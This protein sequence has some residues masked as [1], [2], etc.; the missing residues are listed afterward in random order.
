MSAASTVGI[1]AS[2]V[3]SDA[4]V[5]AALGL[6]PH[7]APQAGEPTFT[8]VHTD[9]RSLQPGDLFVALVGE[10]FDAHG[11]VAEA[12][13]AGAGAAVVSRDVAG[14][15][16]DR[17]YRVP[18]TLVA[19][20]DLARWRRR[21]LPATVV[22]IAGSAGK[23]STKELT[24]A[25]LSSQLRTHATAAN[26]NNR[27]G[28][29][30]TLLSA[31][32]DAQ[33]VVVE[34]GTSIRGEMALLT[35]IVEPDIA[36]LVTVGAE[37]LDGIGSL[38]DAVDEELD[39]LRELSDAAVAIVGDEPALLAERA[40]ALVPQVTQP[41]SAG[42]RLRVAGLTPR[43]DADLRPSA[44]EIDEAG[45]VTLTWH[46][47][48]ARLSTPG[49]H[50]ASNAMLAL[51]VAEACGVSPQAAVQAV[52]D[53]TPGKLRGEV[54]HVAGLQLVLDCYNANPQS[55]SAALELL[56]R[57]RS[58]LRKVVVLGSMLE[59]GA[60]SDAL[61][62]DMLELAL[63]QGFAHVVATGAFAAAARRLSDRAAADR[64]MVTGVSTAT[65]ASIA[66]GE[67]IMAD[68]SIEAF[69]QLL[70]HL[71]GDEMVLLKGSR[72]VALERLVPHFE[73]AF[74]TSDDRSG[75]LLAPNGG[76]ERL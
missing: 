10:H 21:H 73:A 35:R 44:L 55:V 27:I 17:L 8:R 14:V 38:D 31:P 19:L 41:A 25:A 64:G 54:R 49:T 24:R 20:G 30:L 13:E 29:P 18:D 48:H 32:V 9:T 43:A 65:G 5:R 33:A 61:H 68:E 28:V 15:P 52:A 60:Q 7:D 57:R 1:G 34:M 23:T 16:A 51:A 42:A 4:A 2:F 39:V 47:A 76:G 56:A 72:G 3:W 26:L 37:H 74:G 45:H 71:Q 58:D 40:V 75:S 66:T 12:L 69:E 6:G 59:L 22:A 50:A 62:D 67:L 11:F 53:V 70:P 46:R 63:S 36:V